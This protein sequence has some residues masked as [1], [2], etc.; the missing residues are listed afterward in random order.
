MLDILSGIG[1]PRFQGEHLDALDWSDGV[2]STLQCVAVCCSVL[3]CVAVYCNMC[4]NTCILFPIPMETHLNV[5]HLNVAH[6]NVS[7]L[8]VSHL[9]VSHLNV[10]CSAGGQH[11]LCAPLLAI[12]LCVSLP[13]STPRLLSRPV[14]RYS[15]KVCL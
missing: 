14:T 8:N 15:V 7:H 6:L 1:T 5:A 12:S 11:M 2:G 10:W 9:N 13:A 3:Q 4:V